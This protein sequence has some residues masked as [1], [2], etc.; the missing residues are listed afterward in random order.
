M[1]ETLSMSNGGKIFGIPF[2]NL[3]ELTKEYFVLEIF[4]DSLLALSQVAT[5]RS[6]S[7]IISKT[8]SLLESEINKLVSYSNIIGVKLIYMYEQQKWSKDGALW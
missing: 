3:V 1:L 2:L 8:F 5:F 7:S 4:Q 6:S